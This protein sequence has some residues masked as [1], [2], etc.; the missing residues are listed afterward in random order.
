MGATFDFP[1]AP[2]A[3]LLVLARIGAVVETVQLFGGAQIPLGLRSA[4]TL[5]ISLAMMGLLPDSWVAAAGTLRDPAR[6]LLAMGVEILA[7]VAIGIVCDCFF[8]ACQITGELVG[9]SS[10]LMMASTLNPM[11]GE[12]GAIVEQMLK[13]LFLLVAVLL[14]GHLVLIHMLGQSYAAGTAPLAWL[15]EGPGVIASLGAEMF[16]WGVKLALPCVAAILVVD[17]AFGLISRIAP[18][19]DV[20]FLSLPVRLGIGITILG[21]MLRFGLPH[22]Q[23]LSERM[24]SWWGWMLGT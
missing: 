17:V 20:M 9:G 7:G 8:S 2:Q 16:R 10:S 6:L 11:T 4:L 21:L 22:F 3:F 24:T 5:T 23:A 19:F 12:S 18:D 13:S 14:N 15:A 1:V